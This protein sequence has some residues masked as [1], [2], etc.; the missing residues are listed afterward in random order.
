M[1]T[2]ER[3]QKL[4]QE[5]AKSKRRTRC[6]MGGV[7]LSV[8]C[9][10]TIA[11]TPGDRRVITAHTFN[12]VDDNGKI[13]ASLEVAEGGPLLLMQ[14]DNGMPR[15]VLSAFKDGPNLTTQDTNGIIRTS[16]G[17]NEKFGPM[18]RVSDA[19]GETIW[20]VPQR[21]THAKALKPPR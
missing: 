19:E 1:T 8:L 2:E 6:M 14:D 17:L 16:L 10:L 4:E 9:A 5:L 21:G 20:M 7:T 11:A 3:L 18:L 15:V 12:V 13:R